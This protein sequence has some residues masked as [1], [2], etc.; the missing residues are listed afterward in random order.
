[1]EWKD[2]SKSLSERRRLYEQEVRDK[3]MNPRENFDPETFD[4]MDDGSDEY[5]VAKRKRVKPPYE[6]PTYDMY[7]KEILKGQMIG[8]FESK[9]DLYLLMAHKINELQKRVDDLENKYERNK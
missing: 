1:M 8:N 6:L 3:M 4:P 9:Q 7:P 5:K 2:K